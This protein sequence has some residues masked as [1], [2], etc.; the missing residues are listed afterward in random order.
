MASQLRCLNCW[1]FNVHLN[2]VH[3]QEEE[4]EEEEEESKTHKR[5]EV[6]NERSMLTRPDMFFL[7]IF[8]FKK[9]LFLTSCVF[10]FFEW[11]KTKDNS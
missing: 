9:R 6:N 11:E 10:Q 5:L 1:T 7:V 3:I 4:E 8:K 2:P